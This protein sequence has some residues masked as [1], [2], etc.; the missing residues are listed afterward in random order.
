MGGGVGDRMARLT[1]PL[2][3]FCR[4]AEALGH[5]PIRPVAGSLAPPMEWPSRRVFL[6]MRWWALLRLSR[7]APC[8]YKRSRF[9]PAAFLPE[10]PTY[11]FCQGATSTVPRRPVVGQATH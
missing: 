5:G 9:Y 4:G 10:P 11:R 1:L 3:G 6:P 2:Q 7:R 8:G